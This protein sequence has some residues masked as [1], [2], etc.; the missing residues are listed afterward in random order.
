MY[1]AAVLMQPQIV[2][3]FA[4][5]G[6]H[7]QYEAV[8]GLQLPVR[9]TQVQGKVSNSLEGQPFSCDRRTVVATT[10]LTLL[11]TITILSQPNAAFAR[12]PGSLDVSES[13][14]QIRDAS[15]AIRKLSNNWLDYATIDEEGRA[16]DNT[17]A[18]RRILG[19]VAPQAGMAAIEIAKLTPL[20]R[21]DVAFKAV[22]KCALNEDEKWASTL[23]L[24][25]F[26][27]L[28]ERI[29]FA[30][31]KADGDFYGVM[32]AAKGTTQ[33]KQIYK[34]AKGQVDQGIVDLDEI[35]LLLKDAGAPGL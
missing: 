15:L 18:A 7:M 26:E 25:R 28:G 19:G 8:L 17:D 34:E 14:Q 11:P 31:Q 29:N 21:I 13:V 35:L 5:V 3:I 30:V 4:L 32:F 12:V 16:G 2:F 27:E 33:V 6:L 10:L 20:Y 23:D 9:S 1:A 22:R 24:E